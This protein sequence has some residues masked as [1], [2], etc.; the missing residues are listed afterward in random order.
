[1][2]K[3]VALFL[4]PLPFGWSLVDEQNQPETIIYIPWHG[5]LPEKSYAAECAEASHAPKVR[6]ES[7][8]EATVTCVLAALG[9][10]A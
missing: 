1:M 3:D 9:P 8:H 5:L 10:S 7:Y 2:T 6:D 4:L